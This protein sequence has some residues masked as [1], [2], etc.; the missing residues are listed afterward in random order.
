MGL[1][2]RARA[3]DCSAGAGARME[4]RWIHFVSRNSRGIYKGGCRGAKAVHSMKV[5]HM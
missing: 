1:W 3:K 4:G 5:L 2:L